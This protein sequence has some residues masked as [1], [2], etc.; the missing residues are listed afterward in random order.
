MTADDERFQ[1]HGSGCQHVDCQRRSLEIVVAR[2]QNRQRY[3]RKPKP[4]ID[5]NPLDVRINW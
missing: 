4:K 5:F 1:Y 2:F 3:E